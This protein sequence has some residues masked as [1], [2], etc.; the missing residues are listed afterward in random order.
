MPLEAKALKLPTI[1]HIAEDAT[2]PGTIGSSSMRCTGIYLNELC[3]LNSTLRN[4]RLFSPDETYSNKLDK[5]FETTQ[6]ANVQLKKAW[7]KDIS[8]DGRVIEMLSE[9]ALQGLM[10][11]Y[12]LTGRHAIFAS[13]EAFIQIVSSMTDQYMKFLQIARNIPWRGDIPSLNYILTS[14]GWRQ[15]HNGFSHQNPGFISNLLQ[16]HGCFTRAFFPPDATT[17]LVVLERCLTS[18]NA[19]N[20]IVA[21][22][23]LEP[24]WLT[25]ELAKKELGQG[26]M[27]WDFASDLNPDIVLAAAGDYLTKEAL[28]A[29]TLVKEDIPSIKIRFVNILELSA[30]GFGNSNCSF[31]KDNFNDYF[32]ENKPVI[33]NFHG[34]PSVLQQLLFTMSDTSRFYIHGYVENG[35]TTTPFDMHIRNRTSRWHLAKEVFTLMAEQKVISQQDSARLNKKY[36]NKLI[37][38]RV[39]IKKYGVDPDEIEQWQWK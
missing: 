27:I 17:M 24:R 20:V 4:F 15:E 3:Q 11:G 36:D 39:Y 23:T 5:I 18:C 25:P 21:G 8:S 29:I 34:Y 14:S 35:S 37:E 31:S 13:Y 1:E 6:R 33:F 10:Q 38:H 32:T 7:D 9:H 2:I 22:K 12:V 19:V 28:A 26:L 16:K 30:L